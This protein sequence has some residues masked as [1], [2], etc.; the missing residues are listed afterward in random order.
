MAFTQSPTRTIQYSTKNVPKELETA[1]LAV[2]G[3]T[4]LW[5]VP[6]GG[7]ELTQDQ[8]ILVMAILGEPFNSELVYFLGLCS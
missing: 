6:M 4:R 3:W 2:L 1:I 8:S 7:N 5:D